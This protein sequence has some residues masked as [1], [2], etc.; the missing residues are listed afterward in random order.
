M[1][2]DWLSRCAQDVDEANRKFVG[3]FRRASN[4]RIGYVRTNGWKRVQ[5]MLELRDQER[6][7]GTEE[8]RVC[9]RLRNEA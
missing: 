9:R 1:E 8:A 3:N 4:T 2:L 5:A 7:R 6:Q